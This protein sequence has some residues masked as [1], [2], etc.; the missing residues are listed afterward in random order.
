[1]KIIILFA[2]FAI[3]ISCTTQNKIIETKNYNDPIV[4]ILQENVEALLKIELIKHGGNIYFELE[5]DCGVYTIYIGEDFKNNPTAYVTKSNRKLFINNK[6]Y[7]IIFDFDM[8]FASIENADSIMTKSSLEKYPIIT[9]RL[10]INE[11][12]YVKFKRNGEIIKSGHG[13]AEPIN[14]K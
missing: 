9:R 12:F 13:L 10:I 11:G 5:E 2:F 7:P 14:Q 8:L 3:H 4:Y 1:M 6:F